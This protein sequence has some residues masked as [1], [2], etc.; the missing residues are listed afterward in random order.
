M[1]KLKIM[2]SRPPSLYDDR[3]CD[4]CGYYME[5]DRIHVC[6]TQPANPLISANQVSQIIRLLRRIV[7]LLERED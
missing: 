3:V 5:E 4:Y 7:V 2:T 6:F 1:A